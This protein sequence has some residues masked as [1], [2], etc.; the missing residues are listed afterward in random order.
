MNP[1]SILLSD[2]LSWKPGH[3]SAR[4]GAQNQMRSPGLASEILSYLDA[5]PHAVDSIGGIA[6]DWLSSGKH[7]ADEVQQALDALTE[8]GLVERIVLTNG[9]AVYGRLEVDRT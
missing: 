3:E 9:I 1:D 5:H 7:D 2:W 6:R 4:D 8:Q